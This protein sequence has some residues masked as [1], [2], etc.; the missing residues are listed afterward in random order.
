MAISKYVDQLEKD[1]NTPMA[2]FEE[3]GIAVIN[4]YSAQ[5]IL[6]ISDEM[7]LLRK[8]I[9]VT[10]EDYDIEAVQRELAEVANDPF[11][12][13]VTVF[14]DPFIFEPREM[15]DIKDYIPTAPYKI[16]KLFNGNFR[17]ILCER[18]IVWISEYDGESY[19]NKMISPC[20]RN[21]IM[22]TALYDGYTALE[23]LNIIRPTD[24]K[25]KCCLQDIADWGNF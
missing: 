23:I 13:L 4:N 15:E 9:Q 8:M 21:C 1:L 14:N 7:P 3:P 10:E 24:T 16:N 17:V 6:M 22:E 11:M 20:L 12:S 18:N 5:R 2:V 19:T 25:I